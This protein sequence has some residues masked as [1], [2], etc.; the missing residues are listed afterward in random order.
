MGLLY[1]RKG[2]NGKEKEKEKEKEGKSVV[3]KRVINGD[4]GTHFNASTVR[5]NDA[6]CHD[7]LGLKEKQAAAILDSVR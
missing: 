3:I 2:K 4:Y 6:R 5:C 1:T 7:K